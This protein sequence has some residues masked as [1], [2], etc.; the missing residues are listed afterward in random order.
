M[1]TP[2]ANIHRSKL[3]RPGA[4]VIV[5]MREPMPGQRHRKWRVESYP[6]CDSADY[7]FSL[8]IHTV[9]IRALDNGERRIIAGHWCEELD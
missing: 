8:G 6:L 4:T 2:L 7:R 5:R 9:A 1:L 3:P